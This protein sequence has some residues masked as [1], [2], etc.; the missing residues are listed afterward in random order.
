MKFNQG[1][2]VL[3]SFSPT[4]GHEQHGRRPALVLQRNDVSVVLKSCIIVLPIT[5]SAHV[6]PFDVP[7]DDRT[8]TTGH[9]LCRQIRAI[10]LYGR[11][12]VFIE[13]APDDIVNQCIQ[14]IHYMIEK[15]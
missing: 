8:K 7:L 3:V 15:D 12:A 6:F 13:H 9:I 14:N 10:D 5:T 2:I 1:D 11:D 4:K